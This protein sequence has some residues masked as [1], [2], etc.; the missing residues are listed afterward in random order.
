MAMIRETGGASAGGGRCLREGPKMQ[1]A[2][3]HTG[4]AGNGRETT[5]T[6]VP[7]TKGRGRA[8]VHP[9]SGCCGDMD[10]LSNRC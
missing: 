1:G 5:P 8:A 9:H 4:I 2:K 3:A 10:Q 6:V 7:Q